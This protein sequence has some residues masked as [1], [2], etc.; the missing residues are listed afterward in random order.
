MKVT[1]VYNKPIE[2]R[3]DS[4]D[5]LN[6]VSLVREALARLGYESVKFELEKGS[7]STVNFLRDLSKYSPDVIFNLVEGLEDDQRLYYA[8]AA[9]FE[10]AGYPYSGTSFEGLFLTTDKIISKYLLKAS[11]IL[12]PSWQEYLGVIDNIE[13]S[14]PFIIKPARED[15]SV[16]ITDSSI[17]YNKSLLILE[18][19]LVYSRYKCQPL[20]I[21]EYVDGREFNVSMLERAGSGVE[22]LPVAETVFQSWPNNK[23]RIVGYEA[24]WNADSFEYKNT[25]RVF[26]PSDA[27]LDIIKDTALKCWKVFSLRGYARVDMRMDKCGKIFVIEINSNPCIAPDSGFM[28]AVKEASYSIEDVIREIIACARK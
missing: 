16:G 11:S 10:I 4:E 13:I 23:P 1:V 21:E 5:V 6:E 27:P 8:A 17:Y 14:P 2:G 3:P 22:I 20:L 25:P 28:A 15:A 9:L 24:K 26:N 19:P 18:L 7:L 12:T